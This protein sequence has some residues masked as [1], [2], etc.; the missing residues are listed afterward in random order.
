MVFFGDFVFIDLQFQRYI[1]ITPHLRDTA[2]LGLSN[3]KIA[4]KLFAN[5][6]IHFLKEFVFQEIA[7][8]KRIF[9]H[10]DVA[11]N[12]SEDC[13]SRC[14]D[15]HN[16]GLLLAATGEAFYLSS[17]KAAATTPTLTWGH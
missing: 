15:V 1:G 6:V 3:Q 11:T 7:A 2:N 9:F 8:S 12:F 17:R 5:F 13:M 4:E 14:A 16:L 10:Q